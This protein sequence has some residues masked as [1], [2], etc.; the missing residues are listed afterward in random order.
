LLV[1]G[2]CKLQAA[3]LYATAKFEGNCGMVIKALQ[4]LPTLLHNRKGKPERECA[5]VM[6]C[7]IPEKEG[8]RDE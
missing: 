8:L 5:E 6:G 4:T 1:R 3:L 7:S 2:Q